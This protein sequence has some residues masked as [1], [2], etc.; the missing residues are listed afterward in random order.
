MHLLFNENSVARP[1]LVL[2]VLEAHLQ[3][4]TLEVGVVAVRRFHDAA[5]TPR[6]PII[7]YQCAC[8]DRKR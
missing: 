7:R 1:H 4:E 8:K 6:V 3:Q 5:G 2:H